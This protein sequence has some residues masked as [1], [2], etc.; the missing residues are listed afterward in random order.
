MPPFRTYQVGLISDTHGMLRPEAL[1]SLRGSDFIVH[2]G[3]IGGSGILDQLSQLAPV[4]AVRGNNDRGAWASA[5]RETEVLT[6]G[7]AMIYVIHDIA[8]LDLDPAAAGFHAVVAGHSHRPAHE[9]RAGVLFVNP[10]SAGPRRFSLPISAGRLL[11]S[12]TQVTPQLFEL[13][14]NQSHNIHGE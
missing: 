12:G 4:T 9:S 2:A 1:E 14:A 6:V 8:E 5:L 7:A 11:V 13:T 10:G 3:D